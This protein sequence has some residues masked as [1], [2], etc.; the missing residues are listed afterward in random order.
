MYNTLVLVQMNNLSD[1][2]NYH[3]TFI[4]TDDVQFLL[5][6]EN[7]EQAGVTEAVVEKIEEWFT[8]KKLKLNNEVTQTL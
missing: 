5:R 4:Y 3:R 7:M 2:M 8:I 1:N 6:G